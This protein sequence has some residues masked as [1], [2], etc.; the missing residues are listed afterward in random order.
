MQTPITTTIDT[1]WLDQTFA[2]NRALYGGWFMEETEE[3][4]AETPAD[5]PTEETPEEPEEGEQEAVETPEEPE[6][7]EPDPDSQLDH[8]AALKALS[9]VRG[10]NASWR[11]KYRELET[12]LG[13]AK[14][15]EQ[16]AEIVAGITA[17]R[18]TSERALVMENVALKHGLPD[19]LA[20]AL[21]GN[22]RE[23]LE[24][25]AKVLAKYAP[26]QEETPDP[27]NLRGGL[28]PDQGGD[29]FDAK[30]EL[31]KVRRRRR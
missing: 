24:A 16:V 17:D 18:E 21:K 25:H 6:E 5:E 7:G 8:T 14:T 9:K 23:E 1:D 3:T 28:D 15:P 29:S 30:A 2:R 31:A 22:T 26:V 19:D 20:A 13:E 10:E 4:P 27:E 11:T 12:K